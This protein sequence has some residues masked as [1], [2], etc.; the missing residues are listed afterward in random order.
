M[1]IENQDGM[2]L[3]RIAG[4]TSLWWSHRNIFLLIDASLFQLSHHDLLAK[5]LL[6]NKNSK[7]INLKLIIQSLD[8]IGEARGSWCWATPNNVYI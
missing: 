2:L 4:R 5:H 3:W 6:A 7:R 1:E 8:L